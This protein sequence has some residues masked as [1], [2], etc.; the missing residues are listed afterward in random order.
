MYTWSNYNKMSIYVY[1]I[2]VWEKFCHD[3]IKSLALLIIS[4][5]N[6]LIF[7]YV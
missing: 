4:I 5:P 3:E 7:T 1:N 6:Q 2:L